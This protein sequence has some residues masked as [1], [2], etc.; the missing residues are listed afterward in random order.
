MDY[1]VSLR[2]VCPPSSMPSC[3]DGVLVPVFDAGTKV[4][5][6]LLKTRPCGWRVLAAGSISGKMLVRMLSIFMLMQQ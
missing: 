4:L 5:A 1:A 3:Q 2:Y 6:A